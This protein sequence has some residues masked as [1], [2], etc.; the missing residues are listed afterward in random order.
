MPPEESTNTETKETKP[1]DNK[2]LE[3]VKAD[4]TSQ[5]K[6]LQDNTS[7]QFTRLTQSTEQLN[8]YMKQNQ[9]REQKVVNQGKSEADAELWLTDPEVAAKK[10]RAEMKAELKAEMQEDQKATVAQNSQVQGTF[11]EIAKEFPEL[12][13]ANGELQK[14]ANEYF[15]KD[16]S[17]ANPHPNLVSSCVYRAAMDLGLKPLSQRTENEED[18]SG[19][20]NDK[21]D[22]KSG[23]KSDKLDPKMLEFAEHLGKDITDEKYLA[24]LTKHKGRKNW[25]Q[26]R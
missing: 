21:N 22:K 5:L 16:P 11:N 26:Y 19:S 12:Y 20:V 3:S 18:F 24:R 4:F 13:Q 17:A 6:A 2:E 25:G 10:M 8:S 7:D 15:M 1:A 14:R 9:D 23:E